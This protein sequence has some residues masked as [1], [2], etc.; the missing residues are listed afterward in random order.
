MGYC[1]TNQLLEYPLIWM[2]SF[3]ILFQEFLRIR[4]GMDARKKF[5]SHTIIH[6]E[7]LLP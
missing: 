1:Y 7:L 5:A 6:V 3:L 4:N 2:N